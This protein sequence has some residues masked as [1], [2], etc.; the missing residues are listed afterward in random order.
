MLPE[1]SVPSKLR[2][3]ES[4]V[5]LTSGVAEDMESASY[6]STEPAKSLKRSSHLQ[7]CG[8]H[9]SGGAHDMSARRPEGKKPPALP[10]QDRRLALHFALPRDYRPRRSSASIEQKSPNSRGSSWVAW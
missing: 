8:K 1:E 4:I 5:G 3:E 2:V 9:P 6:R 7:K 10:E